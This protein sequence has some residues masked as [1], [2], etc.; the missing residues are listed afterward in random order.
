MD[1]LL[2]GHVV[3]GWQ[4]TVSHAEV[5]RP[6]DQLRFLIRRRQRLDHCGNLVGYLL[7]V[8]VVSAT[9]KP[10]NGSKHDG[11]GYNTE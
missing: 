2:R 5:P 3:F 6:L 4:L 11:Y 9:K 7:R 1:L 8:I 10:C